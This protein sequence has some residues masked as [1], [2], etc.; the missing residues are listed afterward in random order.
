M[1]NQE[2]LCMTQLSVIGF[3]RIGA[4]REL[5]K[6][7][8]NFFADKLSGEEL[9]KNAAGLRTRHWS[10]QREHGIDFIPS[11]DFSLYDGMLDMACLL[12]IIPERY[13]QAAL[14]PLDTYFAMAKGYQDRNFDL[15]ALPMKKWFTT[16]YH[17]IVPVIEAGMEIRLSGDKPFREYGEALSA[18]IKTKP[19]LIGPFTFLKLA[20]IESNQL[21]ILDLAGAIAAAYR[22]I[23]QKFSDLQVDWIQLDEP[24][25]VTDLSPAD[26]E[27]L[28]TVYPAILAGKN[29][30]K[31][32]LQ[33]Y[34][35][36]IRDVYEQIIALEFD[37]IGLDFVDGEPNFDLLAKHGF[38]SDMLLFA[39][40][41][42][43]RNIWRNQ[44]PKTLAKLD[45]LL[46][47]VDRERIILS[48]SCSLL[49][50]PYTIKDEPRLEPKYLQHLAFAEEKL[51]ELQEISALWHEKDFTMDPRF[52]NNTAIRSAK[53]T[54]SD[55]ILP[56]VRAD[57]KRLAGT[58]FIRTPSFEKRNRAQ[59]AKLN[60]PFLPTT[61][62]GSFPQT[63]E[64]RKLRK[65]YQNSNLS[66][67]EYTATINQKI[68]EVIALQE[69]IGLD[70]LVHGEYERNDMVEYFGQNLSGFL[71]THNGWVQSYGTR[72]VKPP[73]IFGDIQRRSPIT[74]DC[75]SYAQH[76]T[77]KPVKGML[78]GP[79][80]IL[81]WS[82]VREDLPLREVAYQLALAIKAEVMDLE[83]AGIQIIQIDEAAFR[84]KLPLRKADWHTYLDWAISAFRLTHAAVKP[85]T[86]IHTHMCYSEFA[87]IIPEIEA[88]D[89]DVF[90]FE[91]ARSDLSILDALNASGFRMG[92]GP[93]VYDIHS[94]RV[95]GKN[96][97]KAIITTMIRKIDPRK[98]WVNPDC[99][100]KTR[101]MEETVASLKNMV[102]AANELREEW[103]P[104]QD[105]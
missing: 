51:A 56:D 16:N 85:E 47:W 72:C 88:L 67:A 104:K 94:P 34:F 41:V 61:T 3:P 30:L 29:G 18:G 21:N 57:V 53:S 40:M 5:K 14:N 45:R 97:I 105:E 43:G 100:L 84:E 32:L 17:Y 44:Y 93:G 69:E 59:R 64:I 54:D 1:A 13:R 38:P 15:K 52:K 27:L 9:Q 48:S 95:P 83:T 8:E 26:I 70:V 60:L 49:H 96:E 89:A 81:N 42:N 4:G 65:S 31:V 87:G 66:P 2:E 78:T 74:I 80:T 75:I 10:L 24:A 102:A 12:N 82:F 55:S 37:A 25:L 68:A 73:V 86:Q 50:L 62:I 22:E 46:S 20:K 36:D 33:T 35:G 98:L 11:N 58:D 7:T 19:V 92:T 77:A 23:F 39:G 76:L 79:V 103:C 71:F 91:A 63:A 6:W 99:G 28:T 101:G 90:T